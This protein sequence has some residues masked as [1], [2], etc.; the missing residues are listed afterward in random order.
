MKRKSRQAIGASKPVVSSSEA[1]ANFSAPESL[2][3]VRLLVCDDQ[4]LVR[5]CVRQFLQRIPGIKVVWEAS[6]GRAGVS[7]A[8]ELQPDI[9]LMDLSLPDVDSVIATRRILAH[10]P[11]SRVIAFAADS[12]AKGLRQMLA[13]GACGFLVKTEDPQDWLDALQQILASEHLTGLT[14]IGRKSKSG[15]GRK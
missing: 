11:R 10:S 1:L 9:V 6:S 7:L 14:D 4:L 12:N 3:C 8:I 15:G 13:A 5:T 2:A